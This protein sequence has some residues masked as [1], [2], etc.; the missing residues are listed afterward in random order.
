MR[1]LL[2]TA[3]LLCACGAEAE[4]DE[5][6]VDESQE[7]PAA[8]P[9]QRPETPLCEG[10]PEPDGVLCQSLRY[11]DRGYCNFWRKCP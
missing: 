7:P 8:Q 10:S 6:I 9:E 5:V 1:E 4:A 11:G 3:V 2:L